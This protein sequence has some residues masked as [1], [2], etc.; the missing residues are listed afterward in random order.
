MPTKTD[1]S[2]LAEKLGLRRHFLERFPSRRPPSRG[3]FRVFD[4]CQ[5]DGVIWRALR[6]EY[7]CDYWGVDVK[8]KPGRLKLDSVRILAQPGW[9]FDVIDVDTYGAPWKHWMALLPNV[10][11]PVT[12]FLT[13]GI[14]RM[15]GGGNIGREALDALGLRFKRLRPPKGVTSR[16]WGLSI[17]RCLGACHAH[18]LEPVHAAE[19]ATN[20]M[21]YVGIRLEPVRGRKG[22]KCGRP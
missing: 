8:R 7:R 9:D 2:H 19:V 13:A 20:H 14:L 12:V 5:G 16:L 15:R 21:R 6:R 10:P 17:A 1:N 11:G 22:R 18:G 3:G 4:A